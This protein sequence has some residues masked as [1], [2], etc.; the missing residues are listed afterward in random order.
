MLRKLLALGFILLLAFRAEGASAG[1]WVTVKRVV[2]GDTVQLSDG[3][4]VRY[5]G[6][7][8]PEIN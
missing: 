1:P 8:A 2:D 3:R 5:I 6:V 7:N 4:S